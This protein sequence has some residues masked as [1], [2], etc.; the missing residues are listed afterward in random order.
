MRDGLECIRPKAITRQDYS[1]TNALIGATTLFVLVF[2]TST[3]SYRF[4]RF[5]AVIEPQPTVLVTRGEFHRQ[6]LDH[7]RITSDDIFSAMHK[8]G[9]ADLRD[10]E[11]AILEGD[12]KIAIVPRPSRAITLDAGA[13]R[14]LGGS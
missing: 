2:I 4:P 3:L 1:M 6:F 10:V 12:G 8:A 5:R 14:P 9:I 11:W 7:E 13:P